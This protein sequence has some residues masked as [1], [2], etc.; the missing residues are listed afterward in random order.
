MD[1]AER[2]QEVEGGQSEG[3][4][5]LC[6]RCEAL[7]GDLGTAEFLDRLAN[8]LP[9]EDVE[10]WCAEWLGTKARLETLVQFIIWVTT[11]YPGLGELVKE[12]V[13]G[14]RRARGEDI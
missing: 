4:D 2:V 3:R 6:P 11:R 5:A 7:L 1:G 10:S 8:A 13:H 14:W 12:R 9:L